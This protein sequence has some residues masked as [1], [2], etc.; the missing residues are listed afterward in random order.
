[1]NIDKNKKVF[2]LDFDNHLY[3]LLKKEYNIIHHSNYIEDLIEYKKPFD[4][5]I[6][7]SVFQDGDIIE[8]A[9]VLKMKPY[10]LEEVTSLVRKKL[11]KRVVFSS[12]NEFL[13]K[14]D[15]INLSSDLE[16]YSL[17]IKAIKLLTSNELLLGD[18]HGLYAKLGTFQTVEKNIRYYKE[19]LFDEGVLE[20]DVTTFNKK[21][22][23]NTEFFRLLLDLKKSK[24]IKVE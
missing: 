6:T 9:K 8:L 20:S 11:G 5:L 16:G 2:V 7:D 4:I 19:R 12:I 17:T 21:Y 23:T 1:M 22:P 18:L 24:K 14:D 3:D 10:C 13:P 15:P